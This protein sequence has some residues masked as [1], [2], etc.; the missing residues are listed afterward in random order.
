MNKALIKAVAL[1]LLVAI[2]TSSCKEHKMRYK[3]KYRKHKDF[4]HYR[5]AG[6]SF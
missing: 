5:G 2:G 1:I 3:Q 4:F 6:H